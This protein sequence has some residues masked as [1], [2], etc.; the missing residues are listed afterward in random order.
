MKLRGR[1]PEVR[2]V[3]ATIPQPPKKQGRA[4]L[5]DNL[6]RYVRTRFPEYAE[7]DSGA[8]VIGIPGFWQEPSGVV[9]FSLRTAPNLK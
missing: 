8:E 5:A 6:N 3:R 2:T 7:L 9:T 1:N 4:T